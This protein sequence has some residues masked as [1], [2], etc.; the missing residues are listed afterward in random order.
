MTEEVQ[1]K[2]D[3]LAEDKIL[4][5]LIPP[6]K[7]P[8]SS[9]TS[10]TLDANNDKDEALQNE[11]TREWMHEKLRKGEMDERMIEYD[12]TTPSIGMQVLGPVGFDDMG[13]N[14]QELMPE[15]R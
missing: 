7:R 15:E 9:N 12:I 11:K 14:I 8:V 3:K 13:M 6:I 10:T 2:A 4:D 1:E 5:I